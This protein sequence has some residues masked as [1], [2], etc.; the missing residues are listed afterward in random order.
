MANPE[1][2]KVVIDHIMESRQN[3]V[4]AWDV[5]AVFPKARQALVRNALNDVERRVVKNFGANLHADNQFARVDFDRDKFLQLG[6][7][8]DAWP[9]GVTISVS[10]DG[11]RARDMFIGLL[12]SGDRRAEL[13]DVVLALDGVREGGKKP[14]PDWLW[15]CYLPDP[16]RHWDEREAIAQ[17]LPGPNDATGEIPVVEFLTG[18]LFDAIAIADPLLQQ[19]GRTT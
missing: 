9:T 10:G 6:F 5:A 17:F 19:I 11:L 18:L 7:R 15:Y 4:T 12:A 16:L 14:Y 13:G 3:A 2:E 8:R 1:R